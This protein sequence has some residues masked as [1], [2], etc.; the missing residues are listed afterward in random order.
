MNGRNCTQFRILAFGVL[1]ILGF[2]VPSLLWAGDWKMS[3][4]VSAPDPG[5]DGGQVTNR[6][7]AGG[8]ST[9]TDG[10]DNTLDV[11]ALLSGP[12]QAAF[13]H[14][15]ESDY[16]DHL[17][18]LWRDIRSAG[19]PKT[20]RIRVVSR[21]NGLPV[22]LTWTT[23]PSVPSDFCH[24][25]AVSLQDETTGELID[26]NRVN[27]YSFTS[28]GGSGSPEVRYLALNVSRLPQN[29]PSTPA[30]LTVRKRTGAT[31]LQWMPS[32]KTGLAGYF[33]WRSL[34]NGRGYVRITPTPVR[35]IRFV[36]T[37]STAGVTYYY[38]V[39]ALGANGCESGFSR[40]VVSIAK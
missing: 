29:A 25:G 8:A 1:V 37:Q 34:S 21:Q 19:I 10:Y 6:L 39:T 22:T 24:R 18:V 15:N 5:A 30:G 40:Q 36:D 12:V 23:P 4:E 28:H 35:A 31:Q 2:P 9:A 38:V 14:E 17:Q 11:L 7:E 33:V 26:L 16:P 27:S 20:W 13:S 3:F 32:G